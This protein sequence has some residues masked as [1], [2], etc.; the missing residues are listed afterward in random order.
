M[1]KEKYLRI[2]S[3][4]GSAGRIRDTKDTIRVIS[5]EL[6][7]AGTEVDNLLYEAFGMSGSDI[8]KVLAEGGM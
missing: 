2:C 3:I 4:I 8:V 1:A 7:T 5:T 6:E